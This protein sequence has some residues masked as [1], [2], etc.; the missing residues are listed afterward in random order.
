MIGLTYQQIHKFKQFHPEKVCYSK[1]EILIT[2]LSEYEFERLD[3]W[4][5]AIIL[6]NYPKNIEGCIYEFFYKEACICIEDP[7][8]KWND[9]IEINAFNDHGLKAFFLELHSIKYHNI[10]ICRWDGYNQ[11]LEHLRKE[12]ESGIYTESEYLRQIGLATL[13]CMDNSNLSFKK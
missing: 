11:D 6:F 3:L 8:S 13:Y 1:H 2:M 4:V 10:K 12:F 5:E 9:I 7:S